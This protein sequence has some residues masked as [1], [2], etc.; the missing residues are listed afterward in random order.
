[1]TLPTHHPPAGGGLGHQ[2]AL[3]RHLSPHFWPLHMQATRRLRRPCAAQW[4]MLQRWWLRCRPRERQQVPVLQPAAA[5]RRTRRQ[6]QGSRT[7]QQPQQRSS[8]C[9]RTQRLCG[10]TTATLSTRQG[11]CL[12]A[13]DVVHYCA[14]PPRQLECLL[15]NTVCPASLLTN[16]VCPA[17]LLTKQCLCAARPGG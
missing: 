11:S 17:C 4:W 7:R 15:T 10:T 12:L 9:C 14:A 5:C 16:R 6:R 3:H 1:M 8:S 13:T 2:P